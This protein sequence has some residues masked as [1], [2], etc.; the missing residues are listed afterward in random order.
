MSRAME[1]VGV[2]L[3]GIDEGTVKGRGDDLE[4]LEVGV[5]D[6]STDDISIFLSGS[7]AASLGLDIRSSIPPMLVDGGVLDADPIPPS[8]PTCLGILLP[9]S[10]IH[11]CHAYLAIW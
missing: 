2:A 11:L 1:D 9:T 7:L 10:F 4:V 3:G 8:L 5:V 6:D